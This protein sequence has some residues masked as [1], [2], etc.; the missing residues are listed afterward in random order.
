MAKSV[1]V[2]CPACRR[3]HAFIPS[4]Y[5]CGCGAP[6]AV[7][8][9]DAVP[10][11]VRHRSWADSWTEVDCPA[12]GRPGQWPQPEFCCP[13]GTTV[14]LA[15][16]PGRQDGSTGEDAEAADAAEDPRAER[17]AFRPLTIRTA[18][19]AVACAEQFLRWL[20]FADVRSA[21][22][23]READLDLR[24]PEVVG[25]VNPATSPTGPREIETLW[26][27]GMAESLTAV[28]FSLA[29]YER[30]ARS[31]ADELRL[32]LFVLDLTGT[33]Q[34]VNDAADTLLRDRR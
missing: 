30:E 32:P 15:A 2:R 19:D 31:R 1:P 8:L 10:V 7:P 20:G 13:C 29:G 23:R 25:Q 6:V 33:P 16:V 28:A 22:P 3:E 5:P 12:C 26:L 21:M 34:P 18:C 4:E 17:S 24:G 27:H 9:R 14:R 11:R